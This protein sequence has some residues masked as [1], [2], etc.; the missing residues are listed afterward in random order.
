MDIDLADT[1]VINLDH[2]TKRMASIKRDLQQHGIPFK[3]W[4]AVN[5]KR[6]V[7]KASALCRTFLCSPGMIGCYLS[8][9]TLWQH[10]DMEYT[11]KKNNPAKTWFLIFEDDTRLSAHFEDTMFKLKQDLQQW[12][13]VHAPYPELI[14]L[15]CPF[16]AFGHPPITNVLSRG[17]VMTYTMGYMVS[18]TGIKKL[19]MHMPKQPVYHVDV[20]MS[21]HAVKH[22]AYYVSKPCVYTFDNYVSTV[23]SNSSPILLKLL[24]NALLRAFNKENSLVSVSWNVTLFHVGHTQIN[25]LIF[26]YMILIGFLARHRH[27]YFILALVVIEAVLACA[28]AMSPK[29][30]EC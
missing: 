11:C 8:H 7:H 21:L 29:K 15:G 1:Y 4:S 27:W 13:H 18:L 6:M 17:G 9:Y 25:G 28:F 26:V 24:L 22:M 12:Q 20:A 16:C 23:S 19:L 30:I 10:I 3:R 2:C 5:G 14:H